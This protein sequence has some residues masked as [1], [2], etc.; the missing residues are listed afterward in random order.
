ML[1]I[2]QRAVSWVDIEST[3]EDHYLSPQEGQPRNFPLLFFFFGSRAHVKQGLATGC[4]LFFPSPSPSFLYSTSGLHRS[5][6]FILS[7]D[8]PYLAMHPK[9]KTK[10][11]PSIFIGV[12]KPLGSSVAS[13]VSYDISRYVV[14]LQTHLITTIVPHTNSHFSNPFQSAS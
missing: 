2:G 5:F 12:Q 8:T 7:Y 1:K 13:T 14:P 11:V 10:S 6:S 3:G 4:I 9:M